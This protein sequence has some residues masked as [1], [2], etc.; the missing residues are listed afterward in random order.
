[1]RGFLPTKPSESPYF[2]D[3]IQRGE[4]GAYFLDYIFG[5]ALAE[6]LV[7]GASHTLAQLEA[8][9]KMIESFIGDNIRDKDE[10]LKQ[11]YIWLALYHNSAIE[12]LQDRLAGQLP[13]KL[14]RLLISETML[15][16]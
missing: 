12:R 1:V 14:A 16:F 8:H 3:Y 6:L 13:A 15:H 7:S 11:K 5:P 10:R 9:A 4:D 2:R